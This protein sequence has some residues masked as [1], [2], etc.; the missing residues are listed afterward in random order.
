[1]LPC[2]TAQDR[3][4]LEEGTSKKGIENDKLNRNVFIS[5]RFLKA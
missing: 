2:L 1:L 3:Q 5:Q 4:A